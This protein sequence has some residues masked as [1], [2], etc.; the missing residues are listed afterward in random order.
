MLHND[1]KEQL[2]ETT[3]KLLKESKNSK[4]ITARQIVTEAKVNLALINYYFKS[5]D[6]LMYIAAGRILEEHATTLKDILNKQMPPKEKLIK[7][8]I[9]MTDITMEYQ[10]IIRPT[11]SYSLLEGDMEPEYHILPMLR[12]YYVDLRT[13]IECRMIAFQLISSFQVM[14]FKPDQ[15]IKYSGVNIRDREERNHLIE[16]AIGIYMNLG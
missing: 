9:A 16:N 6:E 12:E 11:I 8:L 13:E 1:A 4:K 5:K 10:E 7:F 2:I 15:F 3:V 14:F